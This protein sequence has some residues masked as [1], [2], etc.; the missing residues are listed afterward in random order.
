MFKNILLFQRFYLYDIFKLLFENKTIECDDAVKNVNLL[1]LKNIER[2]R[3]FDKS[4]KC[5][6]SLESMGRAFN[7]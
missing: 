7:N 6:E 1:G 4:N 5:L 3:L 2:D